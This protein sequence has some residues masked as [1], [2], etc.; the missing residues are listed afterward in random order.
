MLSSEDHILFR[1]DRKLVKIRSAD[2]WLLEA[3]RNYVKI[4]CTGLMHPYLTKA[5][6]TDIEQ[7]MPRSYFC[8]VHRSYIVGISHI[9]HICYDLVNLGPRE[10]PLSKTYVADL[11]SKFP[12][13][14]NTK[15]ITTPGRGTIKL[16]V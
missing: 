3:N 8:R 13:T 15:T 14:F 10:V 11:F 7:R 12:H 2:I 6:F 9:K 16:S 5:C 1:I 4:F